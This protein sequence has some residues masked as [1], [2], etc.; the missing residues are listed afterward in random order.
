MPIGV[1]AKPTETG[2]AKVDNDVEEIRDVNVSKVEK[3]K[4][5]KADPFYDK[6]GRDPD[7]GGEDEVVIGGTEAGDEKGADGDGDG[8]KDDGEHEEHN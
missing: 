6:E 3:N 5:S 1:D 7:N 8:G 2:N 4:D